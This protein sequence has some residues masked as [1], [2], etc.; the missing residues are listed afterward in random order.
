MNMR[1]YHIA[2]ILL[3]SPMFSLVA[4]VCGWYGVTCV[5]GNPQVGLVKGLNLSSNGLSNALSDEIGLLGFDIWILDLSNNAIG[6][7]L[8]ENLAKLEN[9]K[10]LYL[11]SNL[12]TSTLP[13][14]ISQLY[15]LTSLYINDCLLTGSIPTELPSLTNLHALSLH[16]GCQSVFVLTESDFHVVELI[17]HSWLQNSFTGQ[18]TLWINPLQLVS[19]DGVGGLVFRRELAFRYNPIA[20]PSID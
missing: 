2:L 5:D 11:G 20:P 4:A 7:L 19:I 14:S 17:S 10:G 8:P 15:S 1:N 6:G 3:L 9:L 12:F 16:V 18:P 13:S